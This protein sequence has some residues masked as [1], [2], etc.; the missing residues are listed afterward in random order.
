MKKKNANISH[1]AQNH[2]I[3][4]KHF[5]KLEIGEI[6]GEGMNSLTEASIERRNE[7]VRKVIK[8]LKR[9]D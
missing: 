2:A 1:S 3:T 4:Q 9:Y 6:G 5:G 7:V 8:G